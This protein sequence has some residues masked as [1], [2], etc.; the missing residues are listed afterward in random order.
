MQRQKCTGG[1]SDDVGL[2]GL[3][4]PGSSYDGCCCVHCSCFVCILLQFQLCC[5]QVDRMGQK[6]EA[7]LMFEGCMNSTA[8]VGAGGSRK[9]KV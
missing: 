2:L 3:G 8:T 6:C 4:I 1:Y 5:M 9:F 7:I